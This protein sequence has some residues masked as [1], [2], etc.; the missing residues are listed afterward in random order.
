MLFNGVYWLSFPL[1]YRPHDL[2][3]GVHQ[4]IPNQKLVATI[5]I[6][7]K[8]SNVMTSTKVFAMMN[9]ME[10]AVQE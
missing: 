1:V 2:S 6:G 10:C 4:L 8:Y 9:H 5:P 7:I 3:M